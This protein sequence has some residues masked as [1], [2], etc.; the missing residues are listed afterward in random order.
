MAINSKEKGKRGE[1]EWAKFLNDHGFPARR[2][3]QFKGTSDS[4]DVEGGIPGT[5]AEVKFT[6]RLRLYDALEQSFNEGSIS[7]I[8][9]VAHRR[10]SKPWIVVLYAVDFVSLF[11]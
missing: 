4:P 8:S 3:Q 1:R 10:K 6:E 2:G 5:H 7:E 9:Y 11:E